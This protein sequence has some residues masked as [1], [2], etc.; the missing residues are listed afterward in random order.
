M[1]DHADVVRKALSSPFRDGWRDAVA[2]LDALVA[3]L[4]LTQAN[5][6]YCRQ[7]RAE[8]MKLLRSAQK[9]IIAQPENCQP[10]RV[11]A[12]LI[13]GDPAYC[14]DYGCQL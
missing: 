11:D 1:S 9:G 5:Y 13:C 8:A 7:T 2:A 10:C 3:E 6:E 4:E 14:R 12:T